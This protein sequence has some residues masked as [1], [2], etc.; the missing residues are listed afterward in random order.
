MD[1]KKKGKMYRWKERNT[2]SSTERERKKERW[3]DWCLQEE[4]AGWMKRKNMDDGRKDE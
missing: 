1:R 4:K 3:R 2:D